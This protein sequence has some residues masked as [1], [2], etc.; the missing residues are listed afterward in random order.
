MDM[1][2]FGARIR[3]RRELLRL[4]QSDIAGALQISVQA[5]SKWERGENAPD[6][7]TLPEL[8]RLLGVSIEWL[9]GVTTPES[10]TFPATVFCTSIN[11]FAKRAAS[12]PPRDLAAWT[13]VVFFSLTETVKRFDGVPVKYVGDGF[14]GFFAGNDHRRRACSAALAAQALGVV[15]GLV[16]TL[17]SGDIYLG[18]IG[19]PDYTT[20]D[21]LGETVNTAFIVMP[22]VGGNCPSGIGVTGSVAGDPALK[23]LFAKKGQVKL[24]GPE[25]VDVYEP[26]AKAT[27]ALLGKV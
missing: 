8:A 13:N 18:A 21:I 11:G 5:V 16:I 6:I 19:H 7:T 15:P 24:H 10:D 1:K 2:E 12:M 26:R 4:R 9:L 27:T 23:P 3:E 17:N 25:K 20:R 22:W 14:L